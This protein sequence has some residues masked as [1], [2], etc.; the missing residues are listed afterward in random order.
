MKKIILLLLLTFLTT[1]ASAITVTLQTKNFNILDM[2]VSPEGDGEGL[3]FTPNNGCSTSNC[4]S[5]I[6]RLKDLGPPSEGA[7]A[8]I[9][10][11]FPSD[12]TH[13]GTCQFYWVHTN[14]KTHYDKERSTCLGAGYQIKLLPSPCSTGNCT[15]NFTKNNF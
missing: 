15:I 8:H 9:A 5:L 1:S 10:I 2:P 12:N 13:G 11:E 3:Q 7:S 6:F 4:H 14:G